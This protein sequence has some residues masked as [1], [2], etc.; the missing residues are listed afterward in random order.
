MSI[1]ILILTYLYIPNRTIETGVLMTEPK[2]KK[3]LDSSLKG[4]H[5]RLLEEASSLIK[6]FSKS[7]E[8]SQDL[9][10]TTKRIKKTYL[11]QE[12]Y[13]DKLKLLA[14]LKKVVIW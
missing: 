1:N 4:D 3:V 14:A 9:K 10:S 8:S 11:V 6:E 7:E 2:K 12:T 13:H 5:G